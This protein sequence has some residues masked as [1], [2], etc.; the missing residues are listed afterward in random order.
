MKRAILGNGTRVCRTKRML[1]VAAG[2]ALLTSLAVA[3]LPAAASTPFTWDGIATTTRGD[4]GNDRLWD[5]SAD[6][7]GPTQSPDGRK[8]NVF[9]CGAGTDGTGPA[10]GPNDLFNFNCEYVLAWIPN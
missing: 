7:N 8:V 3:P 4:D 6:P 10:G 1:G 2:L 9:S 5:P